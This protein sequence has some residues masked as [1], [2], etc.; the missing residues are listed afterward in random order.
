MSA[1]VFNFRGGVLPSNVLPHMTRIVRDFNDGYDC[2]CNGDLQ[3]ENPCRPGHCD[4]CLLCCNMTE[5]ELPAERKVR[6][7][8]DYAI[9]QGFAIHRAG[10]NLFS[11]KNKPDGVRRMKD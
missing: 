7:F 3:S 2:W 11:T 8:A 5:R 9:S 6:L 10:L 1:D 4:R